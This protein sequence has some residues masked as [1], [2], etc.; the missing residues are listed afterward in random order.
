MK[1]LKLL[2][3]KYLS[4]IIIFLISFSFSYSYSEDKPVDIWNV[5]D[6][7]NSE[8][9]N[10]KDVSNVENENKKTESDI[11]NMQSQNVQS[12]SIN[13]SVSSQDI[14]II[15]L[16]DPEDYGLQINMWS[17]SDG[18]QLKNLF[19]NLKK[20]NLSNDASELMNIL[21]LTNAYYP[22]KNISE[23]EF[24]QIKSDWLI[25]KKDLKLI[26]EYILKNSII[27]L[28]PDLTRFLID[29]HLSVANIDKVCEIFSKNTEPVVDKYLS[30]V[31][32]FCL[33][34]NKKNE[35]AQLILDLKKEIGFKDK[36]FEKKIDYLLGYSDTVDTSISEKNIF[37]FFL[38][39]RTN[40][41]FKFEPNEKTKKI[42]WKYLSSV[43]L[44]YK[45]DDIEITELD[46]I[47][48]IENATHDKNYSE[49][50]LF[51]LYKRFQFNINQFLNAKNAY[52]LLNNVEAKALI[53]QKILLESE[54]EKKLELVVLLKDLFIKDNIGDA[55]DLQLRKILENLSSDEIPSNFTYFY[56]KYLQDGK[57][58]DRIIK[59]NNDILHQSKLD[60]YFN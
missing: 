37:D 39:H 25:K 17:N 42:I 20:I 29:E 44:L 34:N 21:L 32:I 13:Q 23:K 43:N 27:N 60:N 31:N 9:Q 36:Y 15:G 4:I 8:E 2:N 28:Q 22:S 41:E 46:K 12:I 33:I 19:S 47:S 51:E 26:E 56:S 3:R 35:E 49:Q 59:Y 30:K 57:N 38:A 1:I 16:Y 54:I 6:N 10:K 53:Y 11:Y 52:K 50:D 40:P 48:I 18:D 7:E 55:F 5:N 24:L 58:E 45:I 14:K